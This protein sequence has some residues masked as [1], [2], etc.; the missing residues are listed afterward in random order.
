[1]RRS[2]NPIGAEDFVL[3]LAGLAARRLKISTSSDN[4]S[5]TASTCTT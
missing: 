4:A 1:L 5:M 3:T 2:G